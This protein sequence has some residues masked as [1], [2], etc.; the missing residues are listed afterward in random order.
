MTES[1]STIAHEIASRRRCGKTTCA[2][3]DRDVVEADR[4]WSIDQLFDAFLAQFGFTGLGED[5]EEVSLADAKTIAREALR[6]DLAYGASM[7]S[8]GEAV[9]LAE[10]YFSLFRP[11]VRCFTNGNL[12]LPEASRRGQPRSWTGITSATFDTGVICF[13]RDRVGILWVQDED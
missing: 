2:V 6:T 3:L 4:N 7:M 1:I 9:A 13:D 8:E 10:R 5:R 12:G 11:E